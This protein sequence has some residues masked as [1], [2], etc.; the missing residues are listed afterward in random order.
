MKHRVFGTLPARAVIA[1]VYFPYRLFAETKR[2]LLW[3][4]RRKLIL[5]YIFIGFVPAIL[6]VAFFVLG[7]LLLFFNFSSYL[8]QAEV[9][10]LE[11]RARFVATSTAGEAARAGA[12]SV[13][14]VLAR[15]RTG[16]DP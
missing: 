3:R 11:D 14:D 10:S 5:S 2:R 8:V 15:R 16:V 13:A 6:L 7:F 1:G 9:R 4:V 12:R